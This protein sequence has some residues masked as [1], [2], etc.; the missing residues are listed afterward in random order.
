MKILIDCNNS[1]SKNDL[2]IDKKNSPGII[3]LTHAHPK[4]SHTSAGSISCMLLMAACTVREV[5]MKQQS[6]RTYKRI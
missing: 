3:Y 4:L 1:Y 6:L 5:V 2:D